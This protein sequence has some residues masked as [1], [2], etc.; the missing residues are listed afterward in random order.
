MDGVISP[1]MSVFRLGGVIYAGSATR[2]NAAFGSVST[3]ARY[4]I[5]L[6]Y[7]VV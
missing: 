4:E 2:F 5:E 6:K 1:S 7:V 3:S